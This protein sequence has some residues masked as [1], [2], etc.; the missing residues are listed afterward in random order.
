[1]VL[2]LK[3]KKDKPAPRLQFD[4]SKEYDSYEFTQF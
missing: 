4:G 2:S 3:K 1:M